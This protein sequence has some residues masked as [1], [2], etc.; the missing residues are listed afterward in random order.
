MTQAQAGRMILWVPHVSVLHVGLRFARSFQGS[1]VHGINAHQSALPVL[2]KKKT[3]PLPRTGI[4][5][6]SAVHGI[7]VHIFE[8]L[9]FLAPAV[10][11]DVVES[12]W[13]GGRA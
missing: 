4:P 11:I 8:V 9:S 2:I 1:L 6:Q 10:N 7:R 5:H 13:A 12:G 3:A